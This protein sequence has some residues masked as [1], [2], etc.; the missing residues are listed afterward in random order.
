MNE[1]YVHGVQICCCMN[2]LCIAFIQIK[3]ILLS[4]IS[5]TTSN[6]LLVEFWLLYLT[7]RAKQECNVDYQFKK[8][9]KKISV[10]GRIEILGQRELPL[11]SFG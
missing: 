7:L 9:I 10:N 3:L 2:W 5:T 1:E 4:S 11:T 8:K 6:R